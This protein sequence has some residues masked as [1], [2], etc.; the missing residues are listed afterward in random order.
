M[1]VAVSAWLIMPMSLWPSMT[2]SR[3]E[4]LELARARARTE[5]H[6]VIVVSLDL[7]DF[8]LINDTHGPETG[9]A[10]LVAVADALM[11]AGERPAASNQPSS[12]TQWLRS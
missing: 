5:G 9:D 10:V 1:F 2:G 4:C 3:R 12:S 8:A 6:E 11:E 7:D